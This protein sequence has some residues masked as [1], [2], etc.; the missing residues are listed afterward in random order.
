[1]SRFEEYYTKDL[2]MRNLPGWNV[3]N[4]LPL[5]LDRAVLVAMDYATKQH[6]DVAS[7]DLDQVRLKRAKDDIWFYEVYLTDR[8][9]GRLEYRNIHVLMDGSIW[10]PR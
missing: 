6:P 3:T 9:T 7:W 2:E 4:S 10:T 1:M 8:V 5:P